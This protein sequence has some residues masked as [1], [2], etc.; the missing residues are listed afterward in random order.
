MGTHNSYF[1][2]NGR[3]EIAT[4]CLIVKLVRLDFGEKYIQYDEMKILK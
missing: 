3:H 2:K 1:S 4:T